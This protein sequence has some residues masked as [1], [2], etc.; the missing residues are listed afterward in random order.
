[1]PHI[2]VT[3]LLLI[4]VALLILFGPSKLPEMGRALGRTF[5]EFKKASREAAEPEE[6]KADPKK[7]DPR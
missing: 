5:A 6:D 2:S 3:G 4:I 7:K 1:M